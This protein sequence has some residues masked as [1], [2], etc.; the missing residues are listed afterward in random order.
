VEFA[1]DHPA[2]FGP[3]PPWVELRV[4]APDKLELE[5]VPDKPI[6]ISRLS[7]LKATLA[8]LF[9]QHKLDPWNPV[10]ILVGPDLDVQQLVDLIVAVDQAGAHAIGLGEL[11]NAKQRALRGQPLHEF[12]TRSIQVDGDADRYPVKMALSKLDL[13]QCYETALATK[14]DLAGTITAT[15]VID[16]TGKVTSS[17]ADGM[18]K[19]VTSCIADAIKS[20]TYPT[21]GRASVTV[22]LI[23]APNRRRR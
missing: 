6:S 18:D 21:Q 8:A 1:Q 2:D 7:D 16:A 11:P 9:Q 20:A 14:P 3:S 5:A 12:T 17:S 10:D 23:A 13:A 19:S 22:T 15:F 4:L